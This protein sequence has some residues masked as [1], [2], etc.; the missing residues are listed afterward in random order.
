MGHRHQGLAHGQPTGLQIDVTPA[1]AGRLAAAQSR[2]RDKAPERVVAGDLAEQ[3]LAAGVV[4]YVPKKGAQLPRRPDLHL[5]A[6]GAAGA[7]G[8]HGGGRVL[9][10]QV[11]LCGAG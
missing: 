5:V 2:H 6:L 3:A 8:T 10:D 7:W 9:C 11:A 1:Q 4:A